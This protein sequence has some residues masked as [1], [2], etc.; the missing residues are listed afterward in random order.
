MAVKIVIRQSKPS[1]IEQIITIGRDVLKDRWFSPMVMHSVLEWNPKICWVMEREKKIIGARYVFDDMPRAWGWG[2][3]IHPKFREKGYGTRLFE[4]TNEKLK[5]M[6][7]RILL[8]S[9]N[10]E[11]KATMN[12]HKKVG[13]K[14]IATIPKFHDNGE[15]AALFYYEL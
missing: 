13:F 7:Y 3:V 11:D 9:E 14:Q 4:E 1:D 5:E 2:I 8:S 12:W 10:I 6:G 15:D